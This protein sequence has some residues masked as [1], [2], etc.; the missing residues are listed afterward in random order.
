MEL[1]APTD[2]LASFINVLD[3]YINKVSIVVVVVYSRQHN[4]QRVY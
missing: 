3:K 1:A 2:Q 4:V